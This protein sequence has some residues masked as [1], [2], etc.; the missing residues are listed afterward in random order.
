MTKISPTRDR[1]EYLA[2]GP[3]PGC[4]GCKAM[5]RGDAAHKPH[6][7]ECRQ[8][9]I[10]WLK[11]QADHSVQSRLASAQE[12][13][14]LQEDDDGPGRKRARAAVMNDNW[15]FKGDKF[16]RQHRAPRRELYVPVGMPVGSKSG[17]KLKFSD[18]RK[19]QVVNARTRRQLETS[20]PVSS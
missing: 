1:S 13:L 17:K 3:T 18:A 19:T 2:M 10:E 12:R 8:R 9:V 15:V 4:C 14:E 5:V 16:I 11:G 6:N 7:A 20:W